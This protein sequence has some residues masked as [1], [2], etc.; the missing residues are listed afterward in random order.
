MPIIAVAEDDSAVG[1]QVEVGGDDATQ[2]DLGLV[3]P[4]TRD[5]RALGDALYVRAPRLLMRPLP[6][7]LA[8]MRAG[9]AFAR[10]RT[11]RCAK[12]FA[13]DTAYDPGHIRGKVESAF[14]FAI[15][16]ATCLAAETLLAAWLVNRE[17][18][19]TV[20]A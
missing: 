16:I 17:R 15:S 13:A 6:H 12:L 2:A 9:E 10:H 3:V 1:G 5:E 18:L 19:L 7:V 20:L 14:A 4:P 11:R 8:G